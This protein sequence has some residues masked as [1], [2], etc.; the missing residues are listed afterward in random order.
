MPCLV[1]LGQ[2]KGVSDSE[3]SLAF[4]KAL[5]SLFL[6]IVFADGLKRALSIKS[7]S[8]SKFEKDFLSFGASLEG[9]SQEEFVASIVILFETPKQVFYRQTCKCFSMIS[10]L[11]LTLT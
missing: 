11:I 4:L 3:K 2:V 5:S 8:L 1:S 6:S 10:Y 9:F 7:E